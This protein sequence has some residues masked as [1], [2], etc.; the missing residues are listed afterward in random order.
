MLGNEES[1]MKSKIIRILFAAAL[2]MM[3]SNEVP[4]SARSDIGWG[5]IK[6]AAVTYSSV[7][8]A[9]TGSEFEKWIKTTLDYKEL[10]KYK[11]YDGKAAMYSLDVTLKPKVGFFSSDPDVYFTI[12]IE[13]Q[14]EYIVPYIEYG[15]K[16][17]NILKSV[18]APNCKPG[19]K[20][21]V[22]AYDSDSTSNE[23]LNNIFKT[24][25][26]ANAKFSV[27]SVIPVELST[28]GRIQLIR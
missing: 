25:V 12:N 20:I 16:G 18:L 6:I 7:T 15:F 2:T 9:F 23:I 14:G 4:A 8:M 27:G 19:S 13:G 5:V 10:K 11:G 28:S 26:N 17:G 24:K 3:L 22:I 1:E 21:Q